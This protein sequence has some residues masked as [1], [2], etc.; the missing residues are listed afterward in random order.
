M[1]RDR[2]VIFADPDLGM[3]APLLEAFLD[4]AR[5]QA[6]IDVVAVC[7]CARRAPLP[8][9]I[10]RAVRALRRGVRRAFNGPAA[11]GPSGR[12]IYDAARRHGIPVVVPSGR[13]INQP[14]FIAELRSRWRATL[15]LSVGCLQIFREE[16]LRV[17]DVAVNYHDGCLPQ[18]R[19][20]GATAWSLYRGEERTGYA[21][22]RITLGIDAGPVLLEGSIPVADGASASEVHRA[23]TR[24][25]AAD[26]TAVLDRMRRRDV[27]SR[28]PEAGR[29][30]SAKDRALICAIEDP[31]RLTAGEI[32]RRLRAFEILDIELGGTRYPVTALRAPGGIRRLSFVTSDGVALAPSRF[33][34]LPFWLY[35]IYRVARRRGA[36]AGS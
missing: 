15:A 30:Y 3:S 13:D 22:H 12:T 9:P 17:F 26:A 18:Y 4:S 32:G 7:D 19:G 20:L 6:E 16:L 36:G 8:V 1:E 29:Y 27:G 25:A 10:D 14:E 35:R 2:L 31:S 23:K 34:F 5:G 33:M 21:F 24:R 28:R 11:S